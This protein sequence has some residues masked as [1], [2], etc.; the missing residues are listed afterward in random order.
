M[1]YTY[2]MV[3]TLT[4]GKLATLDPAAG[5]WKTLV[6]GVG[7]GSNA[8]HLRD[9]ETP[10]TRAIWRDLSRPWARTLVVSWKGFAIYAGLIDSRSWDRDTGVLTIAHRE[11]RALMSK[12]FGARGAGYDRLGRSDIE[13]RSL[14]G[15]ARVVAVRAFTG[16]TGDAWTLPLVATGLPDETGPLNIS[17]PHHEFVSYEQMLTQIQNADGG[18]DVAFDPVWSQTGRLEWWLRLGQPRLPGAT[19]GGT[20]EWKLDAEEHPVVGYVEKENAAAQASGVFALGSGSGADMLVSRPPAVA[21]SSVPA[22]DAARSLKDIDDQTRLDSLGRAE[23]A[24][25]RE[26]TRSFQFSVRRDAVPLGDTFRLGAR[27][28]IYTAGDEFMLPGWREG[29]FVS[30]SG[31]ATSDSIG[32]EVQPL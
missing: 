20:F 4:G 18:P 22:M 14:R 9:A 13:A 29:Y 3:D 31:E 21:G 12:R 32:V 19:L 1:A 6:N 30:I 25:T 24:A 11:V 2:H 17:W 16:E 26:P 5:P 7:D 10:R 8:F 27:P 28:R 23:L 15:A